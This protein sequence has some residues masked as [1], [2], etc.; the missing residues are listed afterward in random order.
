M[1]SIPNEILRMILCHMNYK[2]RKSVIRVAKIWW[3][4]IMSIPDHLKS[5]SLVKSF[6]IDIGDPEDIDDIEDVEG[7]H[8]EI[9]YSNKDNELIVIVTDAIRIFDQ[10]G[11]CIT[12]ISFDKDDFYCINKIEINHRER[13]IIV[14]D[15]NHKVKIFDYD[16]R[17]ITKI[18][19]KDKF[20]NISS[21][22][23]NHQTKQL[24]IAQ[25]HEIQ[26]FDYEGEF[27]SKTDLCANGF[28]YPGY[29]GEFISK[30]DLC[31]NDFGYP[32]YV[33]IDDQNKRIIVFD[34]DNKNKGA[35]IFDFDGKL[36]TKFYGDDHMER[37]KWL[38]NSVIINNNTTGIIPANKM[39]CMVQVKDNNYTHHFTYIYDCVQRKAEEIASLYMSKNEDLIIGTDIN[40]LSDVCGSFNYKINFDHIVGRKLIYANILSNGTIICIS[41]DGMHIF[42]PK[43][44]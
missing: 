5:Y 10:T 29:E 32:G 7:I 37:Q 6:D 12:K 28:G 26:I 27:I 33:T 18:G 34:R 25:D 20:K 16:G 4:L 3:Y 11:H 2:K 19:S 24:V 9:I 22:A 41:V 38:P 35:Q 43:Y 21:I 36:I 31:A 8:S 14:A 1:D 15:S 23:I 39:L 13:H 30:T 40:K 42:E 17:L 44:T